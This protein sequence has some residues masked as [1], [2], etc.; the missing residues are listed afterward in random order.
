MKITCTQKATL[1]RVY[2]DLLFAKSEK[3][4]EIRDSYIQSAT[5]H[6]DGIISDIMALQEEA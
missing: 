1:L 2:S 4:E 6:F 3:D 5:E